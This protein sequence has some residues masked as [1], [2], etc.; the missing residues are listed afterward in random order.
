MCII[1]KGICT[2]R[3]V[4]FII[5]YIV[6]SFVLS[7]QL[8]LDI[9]TNFEE[10]FDLKGIKYGVIFFLEEMGYEIVEFQENY[11]VWLSDF[12]EERVGDDLFKAS[13]LMKITR[14]SLFRE[15]RSLA[16]KFV[17]V[18]YY[19]DIHV[20][21]DD[22][23][24]LEFYLNFQKNFIT[25]HRQHRWGSLSEIERIR[26]VTIGK[27]VADMINQMLENL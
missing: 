20:Y 16:E 14:S 5:F 27:A 19:S 3:I 9:K 13:L 10:K 2:R 11:S 8:Q 22:D 18:R 15:K 24:F 7:A 23:D 6:I 26:A 17:S 12:S 1:L 21:N 4:F 25:R